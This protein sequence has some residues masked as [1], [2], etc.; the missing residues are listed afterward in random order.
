MAAKDQLIERVSSSGPVSLVHRWERFAIA[1]IV[2]L[3]TG[4]PLDNPSVTASLV[5]AMSLRLSETTPSTALTAS[6]IA[7]STWLWRVPVLLFAA[8]YGIAVYAL[9]IGIDFGTHWDEVIQYNLVVQS[10]QFQLFLPH[11]YDYPAALYWLDLASVADKLLVIFYSLSDRAIFWTRAYSISKVYTLISRPDELIDLINVSPLPFR[12]LPF[13]FKFFILRARM[14]AMLVSSLGGVWVFLSLRATDLSRPALAAA[15]GGSV[16]IL[17]WEFGYHARWL[18]S[19]LILAQFVALFILFLAEAERTDKPR[20]WLTSAAVA[21]GLAT[22]TK[23]TAAG[24]VP[25]LWLYVG[26]RGGCWRRTSLAT[27]ARHTAFAV[28]VF[29]VITPGAL[30]EPLRFAADVLFVMH[31]YA[32]DHGTFYGV[33]PNDIHSHWRY[34]VRLWEYYSLAMLSPQPVIASLFAA[35]SVLGL[36]ATWWRSKPLA[37]VLGFLIVFYSVLFSLQGVFIVRN[38][39][40]LLPVFA[41]LAGVG[42]DTLFDREF[43]MPIGGPRQAAILATSV[44]L[45]IAFG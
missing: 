1:G 3:Y 26:L 9:W 25:A 2:R 22:A 43:K 31:H 7:V 42:F 32:T 8:A 24:L 40:I 23:Y 10:Y 6:K 44:A 18:A 36:V 5:V 20:G 39:L 35:A 38:F 16:Y 15:L 45:A 30:L 28:G 17:S 13:D 11:F 12:D 27:I 14:L 21:A 33:S 41:Y 19:D 4:C 29:L 37:G 34:L